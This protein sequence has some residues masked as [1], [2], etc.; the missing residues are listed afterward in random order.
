MCAA[1]RLGRAG[2]GV[3]E[4]REL[5]SL[6]QPHPVAQEEAP[7]LATAERGVVVSLAG[8]CHRL[9]L[10]GARGRDVRCKMYDVRC[11]M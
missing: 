10:P 4:G 8:V 1:G 6:A 2:S 11:K 3:H 5:P 7:A 9:E